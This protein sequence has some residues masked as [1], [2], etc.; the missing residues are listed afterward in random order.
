VKTAGM[1]RA[2]TALRITI[3]ALILVGL[4][5]GALW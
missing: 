1:R 2:L 4:V 5:I 3:V